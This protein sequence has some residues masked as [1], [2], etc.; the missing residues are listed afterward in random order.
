MFPVSLPSRGNVTGLVAVRWRVLVNEAG[1]FPPPVTEERVSFFLCVT[2]TCAIPPWSLLP[3]PTQRSG[4]SYWLCNQSYATCLQ[5]FTKLKQLWISSWNPIPANPTSSLRV[6]VGYKPGP[7]TYPLSNHQA[8]ALSTWRDVVLSKSHLPTNYAYIIGA[9]SR[10]QHSKYC[11][12]SHD[13]LWRAKLE[14][15][16]GGGG[17]GSRENLQV[18]LCVPGGYYSGL[19]V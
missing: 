6:S 5:L 11:F 19:T 14:I 1:F 3:I 16:W 2:C 12:P 17:L 10:G 18:H 13:L 7:G 15:K 8:W 9:P 4:Q